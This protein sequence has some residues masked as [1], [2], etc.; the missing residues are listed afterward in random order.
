MS[1]IE[2]LRLRYLAALDAV[3]RSTERTINALKDTQEAR[4]IA[5]EAARQGRPVSE[6]EN[7]IQ[8]RLLRASLSDALDELERTRHVAQRLLFMLLHAE[9]QTLADIGRTWGISRQLV[10][11]LVHEPDPTPRV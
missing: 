7:V 10:S 9:G 8:P 5:R 11:R 6:L 4:E 1:D 2:E 3:Q